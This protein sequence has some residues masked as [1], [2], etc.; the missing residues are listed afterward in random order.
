M[1]VNIGQLKIKLKIGSKRIDETTV[2]ELAKNT[3]DDL[4]NALGES[5][6][7]KKNHLNIKYIENKDK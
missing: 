4:E 6:I 7:T 2:R 1:S 3:R 5:I